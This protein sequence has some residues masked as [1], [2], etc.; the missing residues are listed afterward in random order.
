MTRISIVFAMFAAACGAAATAGG[1][2][3]P[4]DQSAPPAL[5]VPTLVRGVANTV[6][7]TGLAPYQRD[8]YLLAS[9]AGAGSPWC[10]GFLGGACLT[11]N[12]PGFPSA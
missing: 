4:F 9:A 10:P 7:V 2:A 1:S 3:L 5:D 6:T 8:V 12:D 11:L